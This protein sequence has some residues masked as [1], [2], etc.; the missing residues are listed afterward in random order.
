MKNTSLLNE[1]SILN[2]TA[3]VFPLSANSII[4]PTTHI[5]IMYT[6]WRNISA[7]RSDDKDNYCTFCN[8]DDRCHSYCQDIKGLCM[9]LIVT[10]NK[11]V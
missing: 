2:L 9:R 4:T 11:E 1:K 5:I 10:N 3:D 8:R 6:Y 7:C